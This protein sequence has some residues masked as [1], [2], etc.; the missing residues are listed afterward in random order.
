[1]PP[2]F[3]VLTMQVEGDDKE[4]TRAEF[5]NFLEN[6]K[7]DIISSLYSQLDVL[8]EKQ[9]QEAVFQKSNK[10]VEKSYFIVL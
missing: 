6:V 9:K 8:Q 5:G 3:E 4:V 2:K 10:E 1:M 7:F